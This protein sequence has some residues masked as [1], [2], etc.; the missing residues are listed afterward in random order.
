MLSGNLETRLKHLK[1]AQRTQQ[2]FEL[3]HGKAK[4]PNCKMRKKMCWS[5]LWNV[6]KVFRKNR[7]PNQNSP[8]SPTSSFPLKRPSSIAL[9]PHTKLPE[10]GEDLH[11]RRLYL[12]GTVMNV[13]PEYP[14]PSSLPTPPFFIYLECTS[15][16]RQTHPTNKEASSQ[17]QLMWLMTGWAHWH[18]RGETLHITEAGCCWVSS[19]AHS[20]S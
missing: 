8:T 20:E 6:P 16:H 1:A 17:T 4:R 13:Q 2:V 11:T 19:R 5:L 9:H 14:F 10:S 12:D 7:N 3:L 15:R 18:N